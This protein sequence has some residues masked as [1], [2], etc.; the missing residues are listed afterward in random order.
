MNVRNNP[1]PKGEGTN[2]LP[3]A[4]YDPAHHLIENEPYSDP[5]GDELKL[6]EAAYRQP[7]PVLLKAPSAAAKRASWDTWRGG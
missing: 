4:A 2:V 6:F 5:V 7:I 1:L 3:K